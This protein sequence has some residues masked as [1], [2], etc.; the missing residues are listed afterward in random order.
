MKSINNEQ[1]ELVEKLTRWCLYNSSSTFS[2][3][4]DYQ[5]HVQHMRI[6]IHQDGWK[7]GRTPDLS[8]SFYLHEITK[9]DFDHAHGELT[10]ILK[11]SL[12]RNLPENK[13]LR[14]IEDKREEL[15]LLQKELASLEE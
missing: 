10:S 2:C 13:K 7:A 12:N 6:Y 4:F 5:A 14:E 1:R 8:F 11:E 9:G 3:F 15:H